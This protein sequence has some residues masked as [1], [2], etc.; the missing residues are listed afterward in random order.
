MTLE[1]EVIGQRLQKLREILA[2]LEPMRRSARDDFIADHRLYWA[3]ERGLQLAAEAVLDIANHILAA[4][5][6]CFPNTN[7]ESLKSLGTCGVIST[8]LCE[9][10]RGFGGLRNILV[11]AYLRIDE[12]IVHDHLQ[13]VPED[14]RRFIAEIT[15]WL[16]Q[17][18]TP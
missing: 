8:S 15:T 14:L 9:R 12:G 16:D 4:E 2:H 17:R 10:L 3:A 13:Q 1:R 6:D 5:H 11:H 18:S 7:E